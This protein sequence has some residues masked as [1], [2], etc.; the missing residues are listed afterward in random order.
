MF[1]CLAVFTSVHAQYSRYII[2]LKDKRGTPYTI[3]NPSAYLSR[4]AIERRVRHKIPID[5]TDLPISAAYLDSLRSVPNVIILNKSNWLN[6][7]CI[8]T[9]DPKALLKINSFPFVRSSVAIASRNVT[10]FPS[11][12]ELSEQTYSVSRQNN[13]SLV[14]NNAIEYGSTFNQI[15]IHQGEYL[16]KSGFR[17]DGMT[18][19]ILDAGFFQY[20]TNPVFDSVRLQN[21]VLGEWDFVA[22]EQSVNE[23][24]S[25]G[26]FC[27]SIIAANR[28]ESMVGSAP[29]ANFYLYRTEDEASEYPIE[30]QNWVAAAEVADSSGADMISSSLGYAYFDDPAFNHNYPER[31][32]NTSIVTRGADLAAKK[33]LIVMN[34]A[35]NSGNEGGEAKFVICPA[36][37]DSVVAVGAVDASGNIA[38]FSSWGPNAAGKIKP[39][40]VSVGQGTAIA[41]FDGRP[42]RGNGTS[43]ANPNL[44]GLVACL[45]Q[46]F[47]ETGNMDIIDAVQKSSHKYSNPD[48]RFGYGIPDF[49]K[50]F[51]L[52]LTSSFKG[53]VTIDRC[54][55][56]ISWTGKGNRSMRYEIDRKAPSDTGFLRIAIIPGA[57]TAF[58]MSTYTFKDTL[59]TLSPTAFQYRIRQ[60]MQEDST[61][62]LLTSTINAVDVCNTAIGMSVSPSPFFSN[63]NVL[64]N[65]PDAINKMSISLYNIKGQQLYY[66][67][68]S[69]TTGAFSHIIPGQSLPSGA[70]VIT[71]RDNRK[72][73]FTRKIIK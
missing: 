57:S 52:L 48:N 70:Y 2:Q 59:R 38:S 28:P 7:V 22:N 12:F 66:F 47:P 43:Y 64:I 67:E 65:T 40:I 14:E 24:N 26:M 32:G 71:V 73:L 27:F 6:H 51:S 49:K 19:A 56:T 72:I 41:G 68:G 46:A 18:I 55:A 9:T 10:E 29:R 20:K 30:E 1:V 21:R 62:V 58:E 17:G 16:H 60:I 36:D 37:G 35:G 34:S 3:S 15:H 23:D 5:S 33:G 31:N 44:A 53:T 50:A 61:I 8:S 69:K 39:N 13:R 63:I 54:I 4:K 25:H 45:W 42:I 11:I